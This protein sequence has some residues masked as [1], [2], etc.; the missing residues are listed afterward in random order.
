[1]NSAQVV[2]AV[3]VAVNAKHLESARILDHIA[4]ALS[5]AMD[6]SSV[7]LAQ[8]YGIEIEMPRLTSGRLRPMQFKAKIVQSTSN[9][10]KALSVKLL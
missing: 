2:D 9:E 10:P 3:R 7:Q 5:Y 4:P 6:L 1:M 8:G